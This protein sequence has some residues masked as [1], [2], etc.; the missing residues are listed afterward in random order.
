[1]FKHYLTTALRHFKQHKVTTGINVACLT[2]G[3]VCFLAIYATITYMNNADRHFANADRVYLITTKVNDV[4]AN[5]IGPW[6]T[7]K[8]LRTDV[9]EI[10]TIARATIDVGLYNEIPIAAGDRK[11]FI[12][13]AY[14]DPE[15]LDVFALPFEAGDA[16]DA[17]RV[18][19]S[20]VL[21][22]ETAIRLFG[23]PSAALAQRL[24]LQN[25]SEVTVRG[26][27]GTIRQP[28]HI[29][30][31]TSPSFSSVRF[32]ALL[33]MDVLERSA[34]DDP[35]RS[36]LLSQWSVPYFLTYVVLPEDGSFTVSDL[37]RRLKSFGVIHANSG[38]DVY[39][40]DVTS[41]SSYKLSMF[42]G[43]GGSD[44][45]GLSV[46]FVFYCLGALVLALSCL[47]YANLATAQAATRAKE[48]GLRKV[49]G[50]SRRQI[51]AQFIFE[52]TLLS[53]TALLCAFLIT[54]LAIIALAV[55]GM[56]D[57]VRSTITTLDF[58]R[59]ILTLLVSV[60]AAA[61]FYPAFILSH[62]RPVHA[63][64]A[65]KVRS[66]GRFLPRL[67]V[68]LQFLGASFLL[69]SM[70]VMV[71]QNATI[72]QSVLSGRANAMVIFSNSIRDSKVDFD[73]LRTELLRQPHVQAVTASQFSPW[74][75]IA[76]PSSVSRTQESISTKVPMTQ[77]IV[78]HDFFSTMNISVL[79][80]RDF[81]RQRAEDE[82]AIPLTT[83]TA[84]GKSAIIDQA[85]A[86]QNG[87][88]EPSLA[89][90]KT[91]YV[92]QYGATN[93]PPVPVTVVGVV[94]NH[95]IGI[96][97]P[98][99][100]TGNLYLSSPT[101]ATFPIIRISTADGAAALKEIES[102]WNKLAPTVALKM[103]F[104]DEQLNTAYETMNTVATVFLAVATLALVIS[105]LGLIGM[106]IQ[107]ISR[108]LHEIGVRK[109]LG[110]SVR[111]IV[112]LLLTDFSKPV[113]VANLLAWPLAFVMMRFYLSMFVQRTGL[114]P[115]PFLASF[116]LTILIAWLAVAAQATRAAR[117]NP[118]TVL[119]YE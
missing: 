86:V 118:A 81:A 54:A 15:F 74:S 78:Q 5:P 24:R 80:G 33:S 55:P 6:P 37:R 99:G 112:Q 8:Y 21:A 28:S 88:A 41:L 107:I 73:V 23:S 91:L 77:S 82:V 12:T 110:A 94:K 58:W 49:V 65:G 116:G 20:V 4:S 56:D 101:A 72:K 61:G 71:N 85:L 67:L 106:S 64:R 104:A 7:A 60:T 95:P 40:F 57:V 59:V 84:S 38:N 93:S 103:Q 66:G 113:I 98:I 96:M 19:N 34:K 22:K 115:T 117:M 1:M 35:T 47:N 119:R 10:E 46:T 44:K 108:R 42:D 53:S 13:T 102:V 27:L 25:G 89:L 75:I 92:T 39:Q 87:W 45:T 51:I 63:I 26:V 50:A 62:V 18:P 69:I 90:G 3:L 17:L 97:S 83:A 36:Q 109:T 79:A 31:G 16:R 30:T 43:W 52:A 114:S 11:A 48:I 70:L 32:E 2:I 9:P 105:V 29:K 111:S 76:M 68:G 100:A 14:A